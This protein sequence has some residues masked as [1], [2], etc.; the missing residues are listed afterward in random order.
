[1]IGDTQAVIV[2]ASKTKI[3]I[4]LHITAPVSFRLLVFIRGSSEQPDKRKYV[5]LTLVSSR[6]FSQF[7][8]INS[9]H[10]QSKVLRDILFSIQLL[11]KQ[12]SLQPSNVRAIQFPIFFFLRSEEPTVNPNS[13]KR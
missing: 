5:S 9:T 2:Q 13:P 12:L 1:M 8:A 4:S 7:I 3:V 10:R 6:V 11:R